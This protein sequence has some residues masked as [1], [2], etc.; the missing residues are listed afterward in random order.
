MTIY[1]NGFKC[2][3][4]KKNRRRFVGEMEQG[5]RGINKMKALKFNSTGSLSELRV[6]EAER[7]VPDIGEVLVQ[8]KA[9][10][11]NPSD[12][13]NVLGKMEPTKTP[14]IPGRDYAGIVVSDSVWK[15]KSVFGTGGLLG[16][17][18]DGS[19]AEYITIPET[20]LVELPSNISFSTATA[21]SLGYL[22]AWQSLVVV[23]KLKAN[24][25]VLITG[26]AGAVGNAAIRIAHSLSAE[27][28]GTYLPSNQI[29]EDLKNVV[30]W[31]NLE[32]EKL[33][34]KIYELTNNK[35]VNLVMDVIGG[36]LF[37][38]CIDC[39]AERGRQV[40]IATTDPTVSFNLLDFYH[41]EGQ[42][43]GVDTLKLSYQEAAHILKALLP[44]MEKG[45]F[46]PQEIDEVSIEDAPEAYEAINNRTAKRKQVIIF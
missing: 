42:L 16:F 15:G 20:A 1:L 6:V 5:Q 41:K 4:A 13:K 38:S 30:Q 28:I 7:P 8:I 11:I 46:V 39:L 19:H 18:K 40:S 12:V 14:R 21:M 17:T 23:G 44:G 26:A 34:D 9:A 3:K 43:F 25:K 2:P 37:E 22:T 24:E 10:A 31:V 35:G 29:P 33:P 32:T 36:K 45:I 27:V